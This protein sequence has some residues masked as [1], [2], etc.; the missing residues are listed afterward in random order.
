[1]GAFEIDAEPFL[2][3]AREISLPEDFL[4]TGRRNLA[5]KTRG[6]H[7]QGKKA[8]SPPVSLRYARSVL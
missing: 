7:D 3:Q 5:L 2:I 8:P 4:E 6:I 1:M